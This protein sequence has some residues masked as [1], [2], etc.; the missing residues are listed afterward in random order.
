M[1]FTY[2]IFLTFSKSAF[3]FLERFRECSKASEVSCSLASTPSSLYWC[4]K[5]ASI[6]N[7]L[8]SPLART[9]SKHQFKNTLVHVLQLL[10]GWG[11]DLG[12]LYLTLKWNTTVQGRTIIRNGCYCAYVQVK[13]LKY[14][15][16]PSYDLK[17]RN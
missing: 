11:L 7:L 2:L 17:K 5:E 4:S 14:I 3:V 6:N 9:A 15:T 1:Y 8:R 13:N 10:A 16:I 12:W